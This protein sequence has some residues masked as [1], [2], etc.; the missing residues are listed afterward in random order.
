M[1]KYDTRLIMNTK[2]HRGKNEQTSNGD[3]SITEL[4]FFLQCTAKFSI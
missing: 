1:I 3:F 2:L 4:S